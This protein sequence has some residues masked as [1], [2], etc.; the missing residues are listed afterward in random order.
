MLSMKSTSK[1]FAKA[2]KGLPEY[3]IIAALLWAVRIASDYKGF[4]P[5]T[6]TIMILITGIFMYV[7][8]TIAASA[9]KY[10]WSLIKRKPL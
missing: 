10:L 7:V 1:M 4:Y 6:W 5:I 9:L 8:V 2:K 3:L